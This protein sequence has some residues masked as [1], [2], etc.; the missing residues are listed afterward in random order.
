LLVKSEYWIGSDPA[1]QVCRQDDPYCE[2]RHAR[3]YQNSKNG[4][5]IEHDKTQNGLW[6]RMSQLTV[7]KDARFQAGEQRFRLLI[8]GKGGSAS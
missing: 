6:M 7:V 4:W 1:C 8:P 2:P 5:S 3:L